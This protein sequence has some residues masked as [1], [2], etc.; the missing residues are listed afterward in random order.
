R[1]RSTAKAA[2]APP[3]DCK[4]WVRPLRGQIPPK[5]ER[6]PGEAGLRGGELMRRGHAKACSRR[7]E[8]NSRLAAKRRV[9]GELC[10]PFTPYP[11]KRA[12]QPVASTPGLVAERWRRRRGLCRLLSRD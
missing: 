1:S 10:S 4:G 12:A 3:G 9:K 5:P 6:K 11:E 2:V 7:T 8:G